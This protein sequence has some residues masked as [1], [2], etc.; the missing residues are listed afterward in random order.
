MILA[1]QTVKIK[2]ECQDNGDDKYTWI[3]MDNEEKG[4][5]TICPINHPMTIK[6]TF[7]VDASKLELNT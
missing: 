6:P 1:G 2:P 5:V 4:R 7:V 3:A